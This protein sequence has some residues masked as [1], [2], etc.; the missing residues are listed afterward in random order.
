MNNYHLH[1]KQPGKK[2]PTVATKIIFWTIS[3]CLTFLILFGP[4]R[5]EFLQSFTGTP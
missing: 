5:L 3:V 4:A 2:Q 1:N